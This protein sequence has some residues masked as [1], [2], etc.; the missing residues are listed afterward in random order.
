M[1]GNVELS[2]SSND[3]LTNLFFQGGA[4]RKALKF[5]IYFL[6]H[7]KHVN[8]GRTLLISTERNDR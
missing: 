8:I 6:A 7:V 3:L 5:I 4:W 1:F 2:D